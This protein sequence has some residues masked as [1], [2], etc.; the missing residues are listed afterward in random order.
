MSAVI[1]ILSDLIRIPSINPMGR[2]DCDPATCGE[3]RMGRFLA[4]WLAARS[5]RYQIQNVEP[6]RDNI[7]AFLP[8]TQNSASTILWEVHQDTVP[9]DNM[10]VPP[11]GGVV[12]QG[13]VYGRGACDVKGSMA[14]MLAAVN[15]AVKGPK[16]SSSTGTGLFAAGASFAATNA[17]RR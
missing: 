2:S 10:T 8:A 5:I 13:R 14:S 16:T 3:A 17:R 4:D 7:L 9:V 15:A 1:S 12:S 11:F 6:G